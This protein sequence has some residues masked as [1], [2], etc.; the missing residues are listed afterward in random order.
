MCLPPPSLLHPPLT[1]TSAPA[2][3][4]RRP[5]CDPA[6][7]L[8]LDFGLLPANASE[9]AAASES[10]VVQ[11]GS[12]IGAEVAV[13]Q[14]LLTGTAD[15]ESVPVDEAAASGS[16]G[17][18]P[19]AVLQDPA[20]AAAGSVDAFLASTVGAGDAAGGSGGDASGGGGRRRL[21]ARRGFGFGS[22]RRPSTRPTSPN[23]TTTPT[24]TG[25]SRPSSGSSSG[26]ARAPTRPPGTP[27]RV[28]APTNRPYFPNGGSS[29]PRFSSPAVRLLSRGMPACLHAC[30]PACPFS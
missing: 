24:P 5:F 4:A 13:Q 23:P 12:D 25:T 11:Q 3:T 10:V 27:P 14:A 7:S 22:S 15:P 21:Q 26:A 30:R 28:T 20:A 2:A 16:S 1:C 17:A 18:D 19:S 6:N 8:V 9:A 29:R